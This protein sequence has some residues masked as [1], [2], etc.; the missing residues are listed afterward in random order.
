RKWKP[1]IRLRRSN[2]LSG[3]LRELLALFSLP[4]ATRKSFLKRAIASWRHGQNENLS[5]RGTD[6]GGRG[7]RPGADEHINQWRH[8]NDRGQDHARQRPGAQLTGGFQ[9]SRNWEAV[10]DQN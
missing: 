4:A 6:V 2:T 5:N 8:R 10:Q 9:Q 3:W 7:F 1:P